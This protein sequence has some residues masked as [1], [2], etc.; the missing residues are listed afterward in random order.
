M[1]WLTESNRPKHIHAGL[2]IY[3]T[4]MMFPILFSGYIDLASVQ[5]SCVVLIAMMCLEY[6]QYTAGSKFDWLDIL[7]G[8]LTPFVLTL[9]L[10]VVLR[11]IL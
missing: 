1:S 8:C 5:A 11:C 4:W 3:F 2:I 6:G 10:I 9:I 7:A